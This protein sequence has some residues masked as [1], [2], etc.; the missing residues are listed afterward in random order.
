VPV[1][2]KDGMNLPAVGCPDARRFVG[3]TLKFPWPSPLG[4]KM[5][6]GDINVRKGANL[7]SYRDQQS[8]FYL[9]HHNLASLCYS[10]A[11]ANRIFDSESL[12]K[13]HNI[14]KDIGAVVA[15]IH[16]VIK[17]QS[18]DELEKRRTVFNTVRK[19]EEGIECDLERDFLEE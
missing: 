19:V 15:A 10:V 17:T 6:L 9:A 2:D 18:M 4:D 14:A 8:N 5:T 11:L 3:S 12:D 16:A 7:K 13:R 1:F